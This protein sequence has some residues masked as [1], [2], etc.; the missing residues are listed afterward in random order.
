MTITHICT[1]RWLMVCLVG[2]VLV[3]A[4]G[5]I[6]H[7]AAIG[8]TGTAA[9]P[10]GSALKAECDL[11]IT[12]A[13]SGDD[14]RAESVFISLLSHSPRDARALTNLGNLHLIRGEPD[15]ALA[16]YERAGKLDSL[17][18]GVVLNQAVALL[19]LGKQD[20]AEARAR[21]GTEMAGGVREASSL[22]GFRVSEQDAEAR[23]ADRAAEK[24]HIAKDEIAVLL[25]AARHN[26]PA[27]SSGTG[28]KSQGQSKQPGQQAPSLR[29]AGTRASGESVVADMIYWKR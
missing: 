7:D 2:A 26:I 17:D 16:F 22:L 6:G 13:F 9:S 12:L 15:L 10:A 24:P 20:A 29:S 11:G 3:P 14:A 8:A 23:A 1:R 19:L 5:L 21:R 25:N 18:A 27:D 28:A 4:L